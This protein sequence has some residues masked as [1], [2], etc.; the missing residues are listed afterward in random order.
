MKELL[1][2]DSPQITIEITNNKQPNSVK[3]YLWT[4]P[5]AATNWMQRWIQHVHN[6]KIKHTPLRHPLSGTL[7]PYLFRRYC[8]YG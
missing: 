3:M 4:R 8:N 7:L 1:T 2:L 5:N 6:S